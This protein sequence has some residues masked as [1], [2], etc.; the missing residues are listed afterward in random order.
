MAEIGGR[1]GN[2]ILEVDPQMNTLVDLRYHWKYRAPKGI[3][4]KGNNRHGK[5][6][7]DLIVKVP[8]GTIVKNPENGEVLM[9]LS[10]EQQQFIAAEGGRGGRGNARFKSSTNQAPRRVEEGRPGAERALQLELKLLADVGIIGLPNAGKSTL[11]SRISA[12]RPKIANYPFTTLIPNLGVVRISDYRSFVVVDIPGLIEGASQGTGLGFQFL[13]H[14]E[15]TRMFVH[16]VDVSSESTSDPVHDFHTINTE[17]ESYNP[18]LLQRHQIVAAN[19]IDV[20]DNTEQLDLL[21]TY[22][23]QQGI[24]CYPISAVTGEGVNNIVQRITQQL[25]QG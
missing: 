6:G 25:Y 20:L 10:D 13:R 11:I 1:G 18:A 5:N 22:C 12:A 7:D 14:I 23:E 9:D 8:P 21:Q 15:R 19:K 24:P 16:V 4:G 17:L 2:I 3:S